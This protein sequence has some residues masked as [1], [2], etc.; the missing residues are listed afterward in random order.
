[1]VSARLDGGTATIELD[2]DPKQPVPVW[3]RSEY[4]P[5]WVTEDGGPVYMATP[6][7]QLVFARDRTVR[8]RFERGPIEHAAALATILGLVVVA[9]LARRPRPSSP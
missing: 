7:F 6:T 5:S 4:F 9:W 3:V 1:M 2:R 8:L